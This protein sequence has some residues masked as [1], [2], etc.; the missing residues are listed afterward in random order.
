[1]K[2]FITLVFINI[3]FLSIFPQ[4]EQ[5]NSSSN[6]RLLTCFFLD[7]NT[8]WAAGYDGSLLETSDGGLNWISKNIGTLDDIHDIFFLNSMKGWALLYEFSPFR[9][10]S[11]IHTTDGGNSW[12]VQFN[13]WDYTFH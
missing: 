8:G 12:N 10:G 6:N 3:A 13:I 1:M 11:I 9:H 4:W 7:T 2:I 5:Q